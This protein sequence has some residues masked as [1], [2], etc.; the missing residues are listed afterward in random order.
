MAIQAGR[1]RSRRE[2]LSMT[3]GRPS[4]WTGAV[5]CSAARVG[6]VRRYGTGAER[7]GVRQD[8][9]DLPLLAGGPGDPDLVLG[10]EATGR[11]DL[12]VGEQALAGESGDLGVN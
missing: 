2:S 8:G 9:V 1:K 5:T 4:T 10:G 6:R 11:T 3:A 7:I 12:L